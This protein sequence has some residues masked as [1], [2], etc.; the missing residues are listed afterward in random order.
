MVILL[1]IG[2]I[3]HVSFAIS[4]F[5][6][7]FFFYQFFHRVT[8]FKTIFSFISRYSIQSSAV[9]Q[10]KVF[11]KIS[12]TSE[13]N[14]CVGVSFLIKLQGFRPAT[15][16]KGDSNTGIFLRNLRNFQKHLFW[17]TS[18]Q[19]CIYKLMQLLAKRKIY[20]YVGCWDS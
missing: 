2:N 10:K 14:T 5:F 18:A 17:R 16:F 15:F 8:C 20:F 6:I 7:N 19:N 4:V 1:Q 9:L 12:E 3:Q 13:E 11:L